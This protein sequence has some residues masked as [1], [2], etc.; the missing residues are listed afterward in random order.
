LLNI[1]GIFTTSLL[2]MSH[3]H[4][5]KLF[6]LACFYIHESLEGGLGVAE[7]SHHIIGTVGVILQLHIG[8][9]GGLMSW[10]LLDELTSWF[11]DTRVFWPLFLLIRVV[12]YN[13]VIGVAVFQGRKEYSTSPSVGLKFWLVAVVVWGVFSIVYHAEWLWAMRSRFQFLD[14]GGRDPQVRPLP[15]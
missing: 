1:A 14:P 6:I 15:S 2:S 10:L 7:L 12:M 13:V 3:I 9:G 11:E 5:V 4:A 8:V